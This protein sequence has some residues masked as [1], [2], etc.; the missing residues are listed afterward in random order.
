MA[1]WGMLPKGI[2]ELEKRVMKDNVANITWSG[3]HYKQSFLEK[4]HL[5]KD[6]GEGSKPTKP[7]GKEEKEEEDRVFIQLKKT[8][9][10]ISVQ[11]L[12]MASH[13]H[14]SALLDALNLKEVPIETIPQEVLSL[15]GVKALFHPLLV[16]S[17]EELPPKGATHTRAL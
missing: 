11:G 6:I 17:E 3:K 1:V 14:R 5:G 10:H 2:T 9:A 16:F 8:Q 4:D 12:L 15:M 7:K 13:K